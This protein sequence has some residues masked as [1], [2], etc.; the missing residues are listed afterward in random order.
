MIYSPALLLGSSHLRVISLRILC[1]FKFVAG[2]SAATEPTVAAA[3]SLD[4]SAADALSSS[5]R[6]LFIFSS[7]QEK[8]LQTL[9]P[10]ETS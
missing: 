10:A 7:Q 8:I 1:S 5:T 4:V 2:I 6:E 3:A 9:N